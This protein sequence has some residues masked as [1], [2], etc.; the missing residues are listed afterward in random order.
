MNRKILFCFLLLIAILYPPN[1]IY[2]DDNMDALLEEAYSLIDSPYHY[3]HTGPESF[4]CSGFT[5]YLYDK[6]YDIQLKR[7]AKDQGYDDT[8]EKILTIDDLLPE[9]CVYFNTE[10]D[11]GDLSDHAGIYYGE[12]IVIH[13]S[14]SKHK[15]ISTNLYEN[16]YYNR[17]F[18]WG[19]RIINIPSEPIILQ[20]EQ[21]IINE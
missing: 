5:Y 20:P 11:D 13:A 17:V 16:D 12:G 3:G 9:D 14:S 21:L 8:Y 7:S 1:P 10:N 15:V 18:S 6:Y 19:R 4:D 2:S